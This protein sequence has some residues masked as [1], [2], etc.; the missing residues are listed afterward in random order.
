MKPLTDINI[1]I[2]TIVQP[3]TNDVNVIHSN[4]DD[5]DGEEDD[6]DGKTPAYSNT[7][8]SVLCCNKKTKTITI[9]YRIQTPEKINHIAV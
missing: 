9:Y 6:D 3:P 1:S 5:D 2:G 4:N 8:Q 7:S